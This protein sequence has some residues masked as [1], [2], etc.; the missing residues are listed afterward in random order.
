LLAEIIF[1][2]IVN[3]M[4]NSELDE[5]ANLVVKKLFERYD[6]NRSGVLEDTEVTKIVRTFS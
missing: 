5:K 4:N 1:T 2:I 6:S 3:I